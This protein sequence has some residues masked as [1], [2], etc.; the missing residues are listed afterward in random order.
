MS[1]DTICHMVTLDASSNEYSQV[2]KLF[3]AT[4]PVPQQ[5]FTMCDFHWNHIVKIE[6]IQSPALYT[7]YMN[8]KKGIG[9]CNSSGLKNEMKLFY[10]CRQDVV[11]K[12][13]HW[14][15]DITFAGNNGT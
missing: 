12:I 9:E 6:R 1:D 10:G 2:K 14:G 4:M 11:D 5:Q 13:S 8:R 3:T 7:Q 15:F